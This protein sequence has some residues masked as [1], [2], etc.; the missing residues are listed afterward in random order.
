MRHWIGAALV[1]IMA[2]RL[3]GAKPLSKPML[4]VNW[5]LRNKYQWKFNQNT[6]L[7]IHENASEKIVCEMA[8]ILSR[9]R[10]VNL[11]IK[12]RIAS[13]PAPYFHSISAVVHARHKRRSASCYLKSL[14]QW[15]HTSIKTLLFWPEIH[16][17]NHSYKFPARAYDSAPQR[18]GGIGRYGAERTPSG[19]AW[20][21]QLTHWPLGDVEV[22]SK[23]QSSSACYCENALVWMP[24]TEHL[25]WYVNIGPGNGLV[26]ST[27]HYPSQ[28]WPRFM[29]PY[30]VTKPQWLN[31]LR[32][33]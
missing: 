18:Q 5:V 13:S 17:H 15:T 25:W 16:D 26:P 22:T 33:R 32:P 2:C 7:F 28:C 10:W 30:G 24:C 27:G 19:L 23:V 3:F 21:P 12:R 8:A 14:R 20:N 9:G 6:N 11:I 4:I 1:Q 29:S 31:I